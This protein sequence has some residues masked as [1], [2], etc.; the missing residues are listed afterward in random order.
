MSRH[1][2]LASRALSLLSRELRA[3]GC[4][5]QLLPARAVHALPAAA[6]VPALGGAASRGGFG[7]AHLPCGAAWF[8]SSPAPRDEDEQDWEMMNT[9][10]YPE[11][12][13]EVGSAAPQWSAPAVVNGEIVQK[14]SLADYEGKHVVMLFYPKVRLAGAALLNE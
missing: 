11:S 10:I 14:L 8:S 12:E 1:R 9:V 4:N 7:A 5:S 3:E 13:L 2:T 6:A